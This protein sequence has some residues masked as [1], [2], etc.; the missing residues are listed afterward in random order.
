MI[1]SVKPLANK[2]ERKKNLYREIAEEEQQ[3]VWNA[4][5]HSWHNFRNVPIRK[6]EDLAVAWKLKTGS[7]LDIG[8]GNGR[9]L[10]P[11]LRMGYK[12]YGIDFSKVMIENAKKLLDK[13]GLKADL[14]I[15]KAEKLP[16]EDES[17][18]YC[19]FIASL[20]HLQGLERKKAIF[21]M[22]RVMKKG[23]YALVT[24]WNRLQ[25]RF[26]FG[27]KDRYISWRIKD[28]IYERYYHLFTYWEFKRFLQESGFEITET[29]GIFGKNLDFVVR[30]I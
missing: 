12:G 7:V 5:A 6:A 18:E 16:Y 22:R 15:G 14:K 17:F 11:F 3:V 25:P 27:K 29:G 21:E 30:K 1:R 19:L 2:E 8:C 26:L 13:K 24:V 28:R 10:I 23:G 4:I 20:H 9:N